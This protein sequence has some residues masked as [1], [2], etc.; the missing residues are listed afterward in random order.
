MIYIAG[1]AVAKLSSRVN[2]DGEAPSKHF[3]G[4]EAVQG[5]R[6]AIIGHRPNWVYEP[7]HILSTRAETKVPVANI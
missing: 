4:R 1:I 3:K 7:D 6:E 2:I 5:K